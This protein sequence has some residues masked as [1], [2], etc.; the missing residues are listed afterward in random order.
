MT[1]LIKAGESK[2][3]KSLLLLIKTTILMLEM[4][5]ETTIYWRCSRRL[6]KKQR[7]LT[8]R[9]LER[10]KYFVEGFET[11]PRQDYIQQIANELSRA[12]K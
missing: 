5:A 8:S 2:R 7:S 4:E 11:T 9:S 10:I 6:H 12:A 1:A 3:R